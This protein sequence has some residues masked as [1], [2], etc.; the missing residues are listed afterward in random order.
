MATL[1]PPFA[2]ASGTVHV[3]CLAAT[4]FVLSFVPVHAQTHFRHCTSRTETN[5]T[6]IIPVEAQIRLNG[7][8]IEPG[9][10]IAV[11]ERD[12]RCVGSVVWTGENVAL[13]AWGV[14][15]LSA[16]GG[17]ALYEPMQFRIWDASTQTEYG[18]DT[19]RLHVAFRG[20]KPFYTTD[21]RYVP[22]GIY[23]LQSL[24]VRTSDDA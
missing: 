9:D 15:S 12:G 18:S 13:T 2:A 1:R 22:D 16:A 17:L 3:L 7:A 10:E 24:A 14:D 21:N 4:W 5:A 20:G 6:I 8:S 19:S 23:L 11:F